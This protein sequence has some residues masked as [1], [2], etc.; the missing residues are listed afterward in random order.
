MADEAKTFIKK[1]N[2]CGDNYYSILGV[3]KDADDDSIKKAYRKLALKLHPDKCSE[4]GAEEAFKKV[5]TAFS[6]LSDEK[7]RR[8]YDSYGA[9]G[10]HGVSA[11]G[12]PS[13]EDIFEAFFGGGMPRGAGR[14]VQTFTFN[15]GGPGGA[16][17]FHFG[18]GFQESGTRRRRGQEERQSRSEHPDESTETPSWLLALQAIASSLGPLLPL[19]VLVL[20]SFGM[21]LLGKIFSFTIA[22]GPLVFP[23]LYFT[24]GQTRRILL[25]GIF[26]ASVVGLI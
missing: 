20:M 15:F 25:A 18:P 2:A 23:V 5:G 9:Q 19:V 8:Q 6:V 1:V 24:E 12:G 3:A 26:L 16:Q 22:K 4:T 14:P 17:A 13:H 11:A 7:K 10:L 21:L